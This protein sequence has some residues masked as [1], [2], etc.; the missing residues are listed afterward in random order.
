ML[1][2]PGVD[3]STRVLGSQ[4]LVAPAVGP[5]RIVLADD[6]GILLEGLKKL[7]EPEFEVVA[8]VRDGHAL[9]RAVETLRPDLAVAGIVMPSLNGI[10]A[11]RKLRSDG[12]TTKFVFLTDS[13]DIGFATQALRLGASCYVL[14]QSASDELVAAIHAALEGQ[15]YIA[16]R[17]AP[18]VFQ[19]L[20]DHPGKD[21]NQHLTVRERQVLQL[22]AEGNTL[23]EAA[24]VLKVS[25]RT[26]E[27]HRNNIANKTGLHS[28]AE[29]SRH[30]V[31][32]GLVPQKP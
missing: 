29:L 16:P 10:E 1:G 4:P 23:K 18:A 25:P 17:L 21:G 22:L 8:M 2:T 19:N 15:T 3:E 14:K 11:L 20:L 31:G 24:A 30:A 32:L 13:C 26:V 7:L 12:I 9:I 6:H 27:F 5:Q 28:L